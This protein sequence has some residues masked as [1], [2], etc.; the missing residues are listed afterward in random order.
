M[1]VFSVPIVPNF[2]LK[3]RAEEEA[4]LNA[5]RAN[6]SFVT[7][8][9]FGTTTQRGLPPWVVCR[10][11]SEFPPEGVNA[12]LNMLRR[13]LSYYVPPNAYLDQRTNMVCGNVTDWDKLSTGPTPPDIGGNWSYPGF[14]PEKEKRDRHST[15]V[16][17]NVVVGLMFAS[18]AI[19][20]LIANPF[21]GPLTNQ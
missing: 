2:L 1:D 15:I 6:R 11:L 17:E 16:D 8:P 4:R 5:S 18:K 3:L 9:P 20:Q 21:I 13:T 7:E 14:I 12:S 19:M 10:P